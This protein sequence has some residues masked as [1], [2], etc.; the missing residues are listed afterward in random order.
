MAQTSNY[1]NMADYAQ[2][3]A[4]YGFK[5]D[6]HSYPKAEICESAAIMI[7]VSSLFILPF[8]QTPTVSVN[9]S[10]M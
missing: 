2:L 8:P 5:G 9:F 7:S 6:T 3:A 1:Q 4:M 10:R